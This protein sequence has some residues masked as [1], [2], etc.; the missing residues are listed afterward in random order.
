VIAP[1]ALQRGHQLSVRSFSWMFYS[2]RK[3]SASAP[4]KI[5]GLSY[6]RPDATGAQP[7]IGGLSTWLIAQPLPQSAFTSPL[8][9]KGEGEVA[10]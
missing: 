10:E 4:T 7:S 2:T 5:L 1:K 3:R 6:R 9:L 8:R